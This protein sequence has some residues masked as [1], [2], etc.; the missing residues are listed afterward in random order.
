M[1][2]LDEV[3]AQYPQYSDMPDAD[4]A[5]ALYKKFYY[6]MPRSEFDAK[7]G[8][9]PK[10]ETSTSD[11]LMAGARG[12][13]IAGGLV[14]RFS[15]PESQARYKQFDEEN[16]WTSGAAK[17]VGG[18]AA[19]APIA[20]G[21]VATGGVGPALLGMTGATLGRQALNSA[22]S[23]AAIGGIDALTRGEDIKTAAQIGGGLGLAGPFAGRAI[24]NA[25]GGVK[26][27]VTPAAKTPQ[28]FETVGNVKV[29]IDRGQASGDV[30]TQRYLETARQGNF[31]QPAKQLVDDFRA[32]QASKIDDAKAGIRNTL[33][34]PD[35][36][37]LDAAD[38]VQQGIRQKAAEAKAA[39][40]SKYDDFGKMQGEVHAGA[41][42]GIGQKIKGDLSLTANPVIIDDKITPAAS[43]LIQHID[44]GIGKMRIQ[45]R[46]DP[47]GQPNPENIVGVSLKGIDQFR[48][49]MLAIA[50]GA[51]NPTDSRAA[52]AV[53]SSFDERL[54]GAVNSHLYNGDPAAFGTLL[55]ARKLFSTY[56][57][58]F[59]SQGSGDMAGRVVENMLG[60]YG[61][62]ADHRQISNWLYGASNI[63]GN[64][65]ATHVANKLRGIFGEQSQEWQAV[66][67][68][69]FSKI[70]DPIEGTAAD[71]PQKV[72][73]RIAKFLNGDGRQLSES[74]F[75]PREIALIK[76]YGELMRKLTPQQG[77]VNHSASGYQLA[78]M[79][80]WTLNSL[81]T[82]GG[83]HVGG[84]M[85]ALAGV[86]ANSVGKAAINS[87]HA[88]AVA[89]N[90]YNPASYPL[91][92]NA[93][94]PSIQRG[95][96]LLSRSVLGL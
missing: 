52:R 94:P 7:M 61:Q 79:M 39:Y 30:V 49:Q 81:A 73:T 77:A 12:I 66:R 37:P 55:E 34:G 23:G 93:A 72:A 51:A 48:K 4:L 28:N 60:K 42:E 57:Q 33:G 54:Q 47:F 2:T 11:Y 56:A 16:P 35:A 8:A 24:G 22:A 27:F 83:L 50:G 74:I 80:K 46:A 88:R 20:L 15:S 86:A 71:G 19:L 96:T 75:A 26:G 90:L 67:Q 65:E 44:N 14:E 41:F 36:A 64:K 31:D 84:P 70:V 85:G 32:L 18:A 59:R 9:K 40:Q 10:L 38:I 62:A 25:V 3:R 63:G 58:T 21:T 76:Q 45:N 91:F 17:F 43:A 89:R 6:D 13:P 87:N 92:P 5:S 29:P 1:P 78:S 68:G 95:T 82:L 53:I 69:L